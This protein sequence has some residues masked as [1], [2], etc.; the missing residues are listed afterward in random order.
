MIPL[1][2]FPL[3]RQPYGAQ[4][5]AMSANLQIFTLRRVFLT[6][7]S[8]PSRDNENHGGKF[9]KR[10]ILLNFNQIAWTVSFFAIR[11]A[12]LLI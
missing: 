10:S 6:A 2:P 5:S 9:M 8:K 3:I 4:E 12:I 1:T 11:I 7:P